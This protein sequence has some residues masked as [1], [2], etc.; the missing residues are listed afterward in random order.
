MKI[1]NLMICGIILAMPFSMIS[2]DLQDDYILNVSESTESKIDGD[3]VN[4][5]FESEKVSNLLDKLKTTPG[6][7]SDKLD[8]SDSETQEKIDELNDKMDDLKST[9]ND[10]DFENKSEDII[11]KI[12]EISGKID[13]LKDKVDDVK[14]RADNYDSPINKEKA[15]D[16]V[17]ELKSHM[18]NL[19]N[20]LNRLG[21][22]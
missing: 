11:D 19:E 14:D 21:Q 4:E 1:R 10:A 22:K 17:D 6:E 2:C 5:I 13:E 20:A 15:T 18:D 7:I 8:N 12:D 9:I 16:S 3:K